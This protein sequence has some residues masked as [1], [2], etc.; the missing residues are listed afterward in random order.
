MKHAAEE[1]EVDSCWR[2]ILLIAVKRGTGQENS[3]VESHKSKCSQP[4]PF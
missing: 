4:R 1:A 2:V 3:C